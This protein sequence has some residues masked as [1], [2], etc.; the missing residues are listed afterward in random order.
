MAVDGEGA[1]YV[2]DP[3]NARVQRLDRDGQSVADWGK[4]PPSAGRLIEPVGIAVD[5]RRGYVYVADSAEHRVHAFDR[6]G[7][8][9]LAWGGLGHEPGRF[10]RPSA[11]AVDRHA[12]E[13]GCLADLG[14]SDER[15]LPVQRHPAQVSGLLG[16]G[17]GLSVR[18]ID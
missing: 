9:R 6:D 12:A 5:D 8:W 2:A 18:G 10:I 16:D 13:R 17:R 11:V 15:E 3:F 14:E 1:L 4:L 7:R